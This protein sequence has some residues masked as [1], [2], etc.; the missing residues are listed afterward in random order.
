MLKTFEIWLW[1]FFLCV[2]ALIIYQAYDVLVN[3]PDNI[4]GLVSESKT[5]AQNTLLTVAYWGAGISAV[6]LMTAMGL[7]LAC[8]GKCKVFIYIVYAGYAVFDLIFALYAMLG[9]WLEGDIFTGVI[10]F[11]VITGAGVFGAFAGFFFVDAIFNIY[12]RLL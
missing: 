1:G 12:D 5:P 10:L 8:M 4:A 9:T 11:F 2:G 3:I 7:F 6:V